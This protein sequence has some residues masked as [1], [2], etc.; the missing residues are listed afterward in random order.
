MKTGIMPALLSQAR[1]LSTL[2]SRPLV[3]LSADGL[4]ADPVRADA[5]NRMTALSTNSRHSEADTT[6]A[7][8]L[9]GEDGA[10]TSVQ[11][12]VDTVQAARG[13]TPLRTD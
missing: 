7:G 2:D 9:D 3:V 10:A 13:G 11:A 5:H 4:D 12:V 6:H 1:E 8:L